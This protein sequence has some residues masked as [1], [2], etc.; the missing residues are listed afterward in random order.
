[1]DGGWSG[2]MD[3]RGDD[4]FGDNLK[5]IVSPHHTPRTHSTHKGQWRLPATG[6]PA[7]FAHFSITTVPI[8]IKLEDRI[9]NEAENN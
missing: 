3:G 4:G 9:E 8:N 2:G 5:E 6:H 7:A 1:M